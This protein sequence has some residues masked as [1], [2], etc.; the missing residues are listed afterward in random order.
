MFNDSVWPRS[1]HASAAEPI[2]ARCGHAGL[3]ASS[4]VRSAPGNG[5]AIGVSTVDTAAVDT[6]NA[7]EKPVLGRRADWDGH[8]AIP[9][10]SNCSY[11][12]HLRG[13]HIWSRRSGFH[14]I[15]L[16]QRKKFSVRE[17]DRNNIGK[18]TKAA[19]A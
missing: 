13:T 5:V 10:G 12:N 9:S 7:G 11:R 1:K 14:Y 8:L 4:M 18:F 17:V 16:Q 2:V 19:I 6:A 3:A 15:T